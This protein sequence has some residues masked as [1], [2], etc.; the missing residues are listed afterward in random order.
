MRG[1][2]RVFHHTSGEGE[3]LSTWWLDYSVHGK[4][5]RESSGLTVKQEA[6]DLLEQRIKDR[7]AGRPVQPPQPQTLK[8]YVTHHLAEKAKETDKHGQPITKQWLAAVKQHLGR[9]VAHFGIDRVLGSITRKDLLHWITALRQKFSGGAARQHVN[10]LSNL[11]GR[12]VA[13]GLV[14]MNPVAVLLR[15]E[16][17]QGS[18]EEA[19]WLE[20]HEGALL[21]DAAK[22][23]QP[24]RED[25]GMP[26]AYELLATLLLTGGRKS[27]VLGLEV[28]D[29]SLERKTVTFRPNRWRRL[30]TKKSARTVPL[31]PQLE[32]I[33]KPYFPQREQLGP[34]TLLFPSYRT[35]QEAMITDIRKLLNAVAKRAGW[36]RDEI[37]V[38][39]FR[40][41]Y[42]MAR[43]STLDHG[44]P[45][46]PFVVRDELGHSS[47]QMIEQRY[48]RHVAHVR[49]RSKCVEYRV[50]QHKQAI[51]A[52]RHALRHA[53][54]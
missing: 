46:S 31:W 9:A 20:V 3:A 37:T 50:A 52:L 11:Y 15:G 51:K 29:V 23:Y 2:G 28:D 13:D 49:H 17:P 43:A 7:R 30:K 45:V 34:G 8:G 4:R 10:S 19:K 24:K 44:A 33:L 47:L 32:Q 25:L 35:G 53:N 38:K 18:A 26:F 36:K 6:V 48:C 54:R 14:A 41:S 16:K 27:E 42:G 22:H 1:R 5:F 39:M 12:A 21:L 40:D